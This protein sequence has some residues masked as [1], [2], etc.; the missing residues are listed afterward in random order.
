MARG[1]RGKRAQPPAGLTVERLEVDGEEL[2]VFGWN[3][4][5]AAPPPVLSV[6]EADVLARVVRGESNKQIALA[7][8]TAERTVA[9]QVASLL[10]KTGAASA[11]ELITRY[12][13][14]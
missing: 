8:K 2:L 3:A 10:R 1:G 11:Y 9:T 6:A 7:R 13:G 14:Q 5:P 4:Q 12:G